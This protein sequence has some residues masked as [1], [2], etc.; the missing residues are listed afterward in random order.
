MSRG[1]R[2]ALLAIAALTLWLRWWPDGSAIAGRAFLR[3]DEQHYVDLARELLNGR[4]DTRYFI[5]PT[6]FGYLLAGA[7][8]LVGG[9]RVLLGDDPSFAH[10]VARETMSPWL[11]VLTGRLLSIAASVATVLLLAR[12]GRRLFSPAVG[13]AAALL[14][15]LDG[16]A[17][18][19]APLCGNESLTTLLALLAIDGVAGR[20]AATLSRGRRFRA[21]VLLGLATATKYS[22][23]IF[24]LV[25]LVALRRRVVPALLGAALGYAIGA[26][27]TLLSFE[28]FRAGFATQAAFLHDGYRPE[29]A[30]AAASGWLVYAR[31]FPTAHGGVV[32]ALVVA[33]GLVASLAAALRRDG[34]PHRLLLAASLPLYLFL[35]SGI[36]H[37]DRFLLPAT[38]YLLLHGAW[39]LVATC[40]A[41]ARERARL[42]TFAPLVLIAAAGAPSVVAQRPLLAALH[43]KPDAA[44]DLFAE[45]HAVLRPD[46]RLFEFTLQLSDELLIDAQPWRELR[47]AEPAAALRA[48]VEG[49]L[50]Q[51]GLLPGGEP[52]RPW[53]TSARSLAELQ[54]E[55]ARSGATALVVVL[56]AR[57]LGEPDGLRRAN[58]D[59]PFRDCPWWGDFATWLGTLPRRLATVSRD[60]ALIAAVVELPR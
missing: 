37:R 31:D 35:G 43:G 4:F 13:L 50:A 32:L 17:I 16:L 60:G 46:D 19:R 25:L 10:F 30:Q 38:P 28:Q 49:D 41:L 55:L 44:S 9:V 42:V 47:L 2:L 7:S 56:A 20:D 26:P 33:L 1:E 29:D 14:L 40:G 23:G 27:A 53:F 45:V 57:H 11:I 21:G 24:G 36:F 8:A 54:A 22:A 15:A 12:L 58:R 6:L 39:L 59:P 18:G 34:G 5:N 51:R 3:H 52:L 48:A